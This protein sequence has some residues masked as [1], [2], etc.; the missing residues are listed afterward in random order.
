MA[1]NL[2]MVWRSICVTIGGCN[3][4]WSMIMSE[5]T[6]AELDLAVAKAVGLPLSE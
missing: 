6:G 4:L 5:L 2:R 3:Y 1:H